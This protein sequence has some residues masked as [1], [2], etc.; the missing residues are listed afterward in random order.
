MFGLCGNEGFKCTGVKRS[1]KTGKSQGAWQDTA[2][3]HCPLLWG[4]PCG[5]VF[6]GWQ[7]VF[8]WGEHCCDSSRI[9]PSVPPYEPF[10]HFGRTNVARSLSLGLLPQKLCF[11]FIASLL[12]LSASSL[13]ASGSLICMPLFKL[14]SAALMVAV[15]VGQVTGS[16]NLGVARASPLTYRRERCYHAVRK[17]GL[18]L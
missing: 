11:F 4:R 9:L 2:C 15:C 5:A 18:S 14:G 13:F 6:H 3:L 8:S 17:Y 1:L 12:P 10:H 16:R 7:V